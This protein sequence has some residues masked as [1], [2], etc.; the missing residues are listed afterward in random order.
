M[1]YFKKYK[2]SCTSLYDLVKNAKG[3]LPP[4]DT[5]EEKYKSLFEKKV[6]ELSKPE[7]TTVLNYLSGAY[8]YD[9]S[10]LSSDVKAALRKYFIYEY[11]GQG[12]IYSYEGKENIAYAKSRY[13]EKEAIDMLSLVDGKKYSKNEKLYQNNFFKGIPDIIYKSNKK[14]ES[15]LDIKVCLDISSFT[16]KKF[17]KVSDEHYWQMQGYM[18]LLKLPKATLVYVLPDMPNS[19][20]SIIINNAEN[21]WL[22]EGLDIK[23]IIERREKLVFNC[24][25]P[26]LSNEDRIYKLDVERN[27]FDIDRAKQRI[28]SVR[29]YLDELIAEM[30]KKTNG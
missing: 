17:S 24:K 19:L 16:E 13:C 3:N 9:P 10:I 11:Y 8:N 20:L 25:Y 28:P 27:D 29:K 21:K 15:V 14:V 7:N 5:L 30:P 1:V 18:D 6:G 23:T 12:A 2:V 4:S 26:Y 22:N